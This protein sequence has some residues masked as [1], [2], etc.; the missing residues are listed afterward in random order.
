MCSIIAGT[1]KTFDDITLNLTDYA[2][3]NCS[4]LLVGDCSV[5]P[6][7]ALFIKPMTTKSLTES[8]SLEF[9]IGDDVIAYEPREDRRD[10]ITINRAEDAEIITEIQPI[11]GRLK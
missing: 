10:W 1:L 5:N 11:D 6:T 2:R 7:F 3:E 8:F 9:H 4:V